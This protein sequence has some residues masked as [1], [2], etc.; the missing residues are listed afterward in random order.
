MMFKKKLE[1]NK[2]DL[3]VLCCIGGDKHTTGLDITD[4]L[5]TIEL[6]EVDSTKVFQSISKLMKRNDITKLNDFDGVNGIPSKY[7]TT[8]KG[9]LI[10][11]HLLQTIQGDG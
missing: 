3:F 8:D 2:F 10:T 1:L 7:A 6:F 11:G 9:N 5:K 4:Y